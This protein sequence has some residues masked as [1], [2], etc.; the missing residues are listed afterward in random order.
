MQP[1][2]NCFPYPIFDVDNPWEHVKTRRRYGTG[3][4]VFWQGS[5]VEHLYYIKKG[6]VKCILYDPKGRSRIICLVSAGGYFGEPSWFLDCPACHTAQAILDTEVILI[7]HSQFSEASSKQ[8]ILLDIIKCE[9]QKLVNWTNHALIANQLLRQ[10][11]AFLLYCLCEQYGEQTE[12]SVFVSFSHQELSEL[13]GYTRVAVTNILNQ[14][15][16]LDIIR[17]KRKKIIILDKD[18]LLAEANCEKAR[19]I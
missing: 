9:A 6:L 5:A 19:K 1:A 17:L 14:M 3:D 12:E 13:L 10:Q 8:K 15:V 2:N 11:L 16:Y 4:I 7:N 18:K